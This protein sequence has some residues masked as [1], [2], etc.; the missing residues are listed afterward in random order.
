MSAHIS[1]CGGEST[2]A[3]DSERLGSNVGFL[4]DS[5]LTFGKLLLVPETPIPLLQD[6]YY[7]ISLFVSKD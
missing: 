3:L 5:L 2:L 7:S 6:K 4:S 1:L